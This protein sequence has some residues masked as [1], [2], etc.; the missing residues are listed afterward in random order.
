MEPGLIDVKGRRTPP[1]RK[2]LDNGNGTTIL[3]YDG[4]DSKDYGAKRPARANYTARDQ[5]TK[6]K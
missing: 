3:R 6:K 1:V 5:I 2:A 4:K